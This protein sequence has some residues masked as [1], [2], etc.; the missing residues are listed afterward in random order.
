MTTN[1]TKIEAGTYELI[2]ESYNSLS[3]AQ[4]ALKTDSVIIQISYF[5]P[6]PEEQL[7]LI[8]PSFKKELVLEVLELGKKTVWTLP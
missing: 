4:S 5:E 6:E 2:I 1:G 7:E 8:K 3:I